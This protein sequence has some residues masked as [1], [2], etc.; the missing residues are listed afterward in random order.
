MA[1]HDPARL[2]GQHVCLLIDFENLVYGLSEMCGEDRLPDELNV[3]LLF[4]LAE[5]YGNVVV[6]NA[7]ADW[8]SRTVNQF[9]IDLYNQ[10]VE[11]VHV[12][13]KKGKNAVDVKMAVD[14]VEM[15]FTFPHIETFVIVSGDRDFIHVLKSLRRRGKRIVG[16]APA[17]ATSEDFA[18]LCDRFLR[19]SALVR[20]DGAR[21]EMVDELRA[22][23]ARILA[24]C[25]EDGLAGSRVKPLLRRELS[26]TFDEREYGFSRM[27][28][29][30]RAFP[31]VVRTESMPGGTDVLCFPAGGGRGRR[32]RWSGSGAARHEVRPAPRRE[33]PLREADLSTY[34]Y[35]K[36]AA[37]RRAIL[38]QILEPILERDTFSWSEISDTVHEGTAAE[39][40]SKV[41]AGY[42]AIFR[43]TKAFVPVPDQD[44]ALPLKEREF[45]LVDDLREPEAFCRRYESGIVHKLV[46]KLGEERVTD[47]V[48][49]EVLG[50]RP[51]DEEDLD[52]ASDLRAEVIAGLRPAEPPEEEDVPVEVAAT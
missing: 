47:E 17:V 29:L 27:P 20:S 34:R 11:L 44:D 33:D 13:G 24:E 48:V 22:A 46:A 19:Y 1:N 32:G 39:L 23:L 15:L 43:Q 31:E 7:Y 30:L 45:E 49:L 42:F 38:G 6:A 26:P 16:V 3:N 5:E 50:L 51:D 52:Y 12:V 9:Q 40:S 35:E 8:R 41:L 21:G 25:A 37:R 10:G 2:N 36:H 14:A 28:Q 18:A 4:G